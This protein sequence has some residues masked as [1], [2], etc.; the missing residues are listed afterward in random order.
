MHRGVR[1]E[2][3]KAIIR[4]NSGIQIVM[5]RLGGQ[6]RDALRLWRRETDHLMLELD[7]KVHS[8]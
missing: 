7:F 4:L 8:R 6:L 5:K 2:D 3:T 1:G